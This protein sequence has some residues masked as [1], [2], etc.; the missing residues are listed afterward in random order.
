MVS[1]TELIEHLP[2]L[3]RYRDAPVSEPAD[4]PIYL[5]SREARRSVKMILTGEGSDELLGGYSKHFAE[6]FT[7]AYQILPGRVRHKLVEPLI[8]ALPFRFR[9]IKTA[10]TTMD[11]ESEEL[12]MVRWFGALSPDEIADLL[13]VRPV[14]NGE[15]P[16]FLSIRVQTSARYVGSCT[17][18]RRVGCRT[19]CSNGATA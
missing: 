1:H 13:K 12:R 17:S 8:G 16:R 2:T 7:P 10:V 15:N 3:V 11:L 19:T 18:T 6:R 9:R 14:R 5:L 4:I